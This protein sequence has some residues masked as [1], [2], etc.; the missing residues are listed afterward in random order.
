MDLTTMVEKHYRIDKIDGVGV[1]HLSSFQKQALVIGINR[2]LYDGHFFIDQLDTIASMM[3]REIPTEDRDSFRLLHCSRW[4]DLDP[5]FRAEVREKIITTLGLSLTPSSEK[6]PD[7]SDW[8]ENVTD[9]TPK[10]KMS[11][12]LSPLRRLLN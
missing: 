12:I 10:E 9:I 8:G 5:K 1:S 4:E 11:G 6:K 7:D 2:L 3:K